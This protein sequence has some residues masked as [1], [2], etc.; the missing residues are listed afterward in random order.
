VLSAETMLM[1][2]L[3]A[4]TRSWLESIGLTIL[5]SVAYALEAMLMFMACAAAKGRDGAH[6]LCCGRMSC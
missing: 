2:V 6:G 3:C 4:A 5:V 1:S